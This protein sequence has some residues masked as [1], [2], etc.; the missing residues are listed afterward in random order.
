MIQR[1]RQKLQEL[2]AIGQE[3][4]ANPASQPIGQPASQ[5]SLIPEPSEVELALQNI[6]P[7]DLTPRAA[8]DLLY[9]LKGMV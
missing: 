2:E 8:L 1:A 4:A 6:N 9:K 5:L 3:V 7:D